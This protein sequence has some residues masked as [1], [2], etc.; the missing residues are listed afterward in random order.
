[1][2][3]SLPE[4]P[5]PEIQ[6]QRWC[7]VAAH[8]EPD[9]LCST[10]AANIAGATLFLT[11]ADATPLVVVEPVTLGSTIDLDLGQTAELIATLCALFTAAGGR[12]DE[13]GQPVQVI[14]LRDRPA[15]VPVPRQLIAGAE[16]G[17]GQ[18]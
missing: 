17:E 5:S 10:S 14:D 13:I 1:M 18:R 12:V 8:T 16:R 15:P 3:I 7:D 4:S 9:D 2:N 11:A 6:H